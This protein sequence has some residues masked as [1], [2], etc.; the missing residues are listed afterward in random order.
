MIV[1]L[2]NENV[3]TYFN[4]VGS[5]LVHQGDLGNADNGLRGLFSEPKTNVPY[6]CLVSGRKFA[7]YESK[8]RRFFPTVATN[9]VGS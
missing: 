2:I 6:G 1:L 9:Y 7:E 5:L 4:L 3:A 8:C